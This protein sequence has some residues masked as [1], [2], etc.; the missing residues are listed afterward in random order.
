MLLINVS[1][2]L[3]LKRLETHNKLCNGS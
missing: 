2:S 3:S 1:R